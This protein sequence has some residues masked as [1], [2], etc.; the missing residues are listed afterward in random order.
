[1]GNYAYAALLS[2]MVTGVLEA[3]PFSII[4]EYPGP[5][6]NIQ[7]VY[8]TDQGFFQDAV[9]IE[10]TISFL[11]FDQEPLTSS[12]LFSTAVP[13]QFQAIIEIPK[14]AVAFQITF[15]D[16]A[17]GQKDNYFGQGYYQFL[18]EHN[19][20]KLLKFSRSA[21]A[22]SMIYAGRT[23]YQSFVLN[24]AKGLELLE[25]ERKENPQLLSMLSWLEIYLDAALEKKNEAAVLVVKDALKSIPDNI[26][27]SEMDGIKLLGIYRK[28]NERTKASQLE[29]KIIKQYPKGLLM[30]QKEIDK[31]SQINSFK[32]KLKQYDFIAKNYFVS[33][34]G[35]EDHKQWSL[36]AS[37]MANYCG[38]SEIEDF[39]AFQNMVD[40]QRILSGIP[41]RQPSF[42]KNLSNMALVLAGEGL[43][44]PPANLPEAFNMA[45]QSLQIIR[46]IINGAQDSKP[47]YLTLP[48]YEK[49]LLREYAS[50]AHNY[51]LILYKMGEYEDALR[52]Q[53]VAIENAPDQLA[54]YDRKA[55]YLEKNDGPE[56]T[57]AFIKERLLIGQF[58]PTLENLLE[59]LYIKKA[60]SNFP[61][62]LNELQD[63]MS[64]AILE[65]IQKQL[66]R[67]PI[68]DFNF[69]DVQGNSMEWKT[70]KG[71]PVVIAFGATWNPICQNLFLKLN[72]LDEIF[73]STENVVFKY[74]SINDYF[75][76]LKP[77][78]SKMPVLLDEEQVLS[79]QF[80]VEGIPNLFVI[81]DVGEIRFWMKSQDFRDQQWASDLKAMI[82]WVT[83]K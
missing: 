24:E 27:D 9:E 20:E 52:Y 59:E 51:A 22:M 71:K 12:L 40:E 32:E 68:S 35:K 16:M 47:R 82:E 63:S 21:I 38:I 43:N 39:W 31:L 56:A 81:D 28:L 60:K 72:E 37:S 83:T 34:L 79:K 54:Y 4:P 29:T 45:R 23:P 1:M 41:H 70:L 17:S 15:E 11:F 46:D 76:D 73:S 33:P 3:V 44:E 67:K 64:T 25:E 75:Q 6:Q 5:G 80:Q 10:A 19:T 18:Y 61:D 53:E 69:T 13:G 65:K 66:I 58:S 14:E 26:S 49:I 42:A 48:Q 30:R 2:V 62:Y 77:A 8:H 74:V 55:F 50:L 7:I 78:N 36:L 57:I